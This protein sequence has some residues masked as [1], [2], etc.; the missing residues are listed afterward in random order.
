[1]ADP[2]VDYRG[3]FVCPA[4]LPTRWCWWGA[5]PRRQHGRACQRGVGGGGLPPCGTDTT[6][7]LTRRAPSTCRS[8]H[9]DDAPTRR[10]HGVR[11]KGQRVAVYVCMYAFVFV[12][13]W[14]RGCLY[15]CVA[16]NGRGV[17][18]V[19]RVP[20]MDAWVG[21]AAARAAAATLF[22]AGFV[23]RRTRQTAAKVLASA[24]QHDHVTTD[25]RCE[26]THAPTHQQTHTHA[27]T[28]TCLQTHT[29]A[30]THIYGKA[31]R[32]L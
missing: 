30:H 14:E 4:T 27:H 17:G 28:C 18:T 10:C 12:H 22:H 5:P 8:L 20:E 31:T 26:R 16:A 13:M 29:H 9:L 11:Q 3:A 24:R 6:G 23:H 32:C 25:C 21:A 15:V 2:G 7:H 19:V 1:M